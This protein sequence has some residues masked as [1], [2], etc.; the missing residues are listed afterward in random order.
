MGSEQGIRNQQ[1]FL[2]KAQR[3]VPAKWWKYRSISF[4]VKNKAEFV[5]ISIIIVLP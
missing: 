3:K 1:R 2:S 5:D 4:K